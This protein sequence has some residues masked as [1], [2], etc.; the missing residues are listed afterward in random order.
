MWNAYWCLRSDIMTNSRVFKALVENSTST[1][2]AMSHL[3]APNTFLNWTG[4]TWAASPGSGSSSYQLHWSSCTSPPVIDPFSF[5]AYGY[6]S[7][8]LNVAFANR[9]RSHQC[10]CVELDARGNTQA[11]GA[12]FSC[13]HLN[14]ADMVLICRC[15][16]LPR[17]TSGS[18]WATFISYMARAV[19][20]PARQVVF[21]ALAW[22]GL[23]RTVR[24]PWR[25][26]RCGTN[27]VMCAPRSRA[28][29]LSICFSAS[30]LVLFVSFVFGALLV[31][32]P[33]ASM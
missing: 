17:F 29:F 21:S 4:H 5:V 30:V 13:P 26:G 28:L 9:T 31:L 18:G 12:A 1:V 6:A 14:L 25:F 2:E 16:G 22:T 27:C 33:C 7:C 3:V 11:Q 10:D 8:T 32:A 24:F 20:I 15:S 19:G 23:I